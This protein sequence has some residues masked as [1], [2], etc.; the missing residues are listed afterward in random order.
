MSRARP[1][2]INGETH[3]FDTGK[4][5]RKAT[6]KQIELLA[7]VEQV[8]IDDLLESNITQGEVIRRLREALG[9]PQVIPHW[10]LEKRQKWRRERAEQPNCR[11]CG[12][13]G[14]SS[15]H[16]FVNKWIL[17]ELSNYA[18]KWSS[19]KENCIPLCID[20]HRDLHY[21]DNGPVS[22]APYL[23]DA[24]KQYAD[25]ALSAL[26]EE[27]PRLL[28]LIAKGDDSVYEARL[29]KDWIEGKFEVSAEAKLATSELVSGSV[30]PLAQVA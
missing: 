22:I 23:T 1:I 13:V 4:N 15:K 17:R 19:R 8:E 26:A 5:H 9:T 11:M 3:W 7:T 6:D 24:E 29:A 2:T 10:V 16:H 14:D 21:R 20:C 18:S 30:A 25:R 12:K 28:I 27:R